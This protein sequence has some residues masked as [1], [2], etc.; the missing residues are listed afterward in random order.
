MKHLQKKTKKKNTT[1]EMLYCC[2]YKHH[3]YAMEGKNVMA[4]GMRITSK[5]TGAVLFYTSKAHILF[6]CYHDISRMSSEYIY[7][8]AWLCP[9]VRSFVRPSVR[10]CVRV[11]NGSGSRIPDELSPVTREVHGHR[12]KHHV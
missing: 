11:K 9:W 12:S 6:S 5:L 4:E 2:Q 3:A 1:A 8:Y 7:Y 10:P